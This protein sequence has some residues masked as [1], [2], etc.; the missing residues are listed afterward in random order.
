MVGYIFPENANN[1]ICDDGGNKIEYVTHW[2]PLDE[3]ALT[4]PPE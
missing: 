1:F 4:L 3:L 2:I